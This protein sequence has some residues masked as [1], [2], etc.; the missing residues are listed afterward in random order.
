MWKDRRATIIALLGAAFVAACGGGESNPNPSP[1]TL[2]KA[3]ADDGDQ[4]TGP[5]SN[6]LPN[7]L[8]VIVTR[9]GTPEFGVTVAWATN[10]GSLNPTS[11]T[12]DPSG[13]ATSTWVLGEDAGAQAAVA[14]VQGATGSPVTFTA[15]ATSAL[16]PP[17]PPNQ[18]EVTVGN[19]FFESDRNGTSNQAVDT[20]AVNGTVTWTWVNTGAVSHSVQSTGSPSFTSSNVQ[21]GDNSTYQFQFTTAG[22]YSYNCAVHGNQMTGRIVVR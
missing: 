8:R 17:P 5:V 2:A 10:D 9:D 22:T 11:G 19:N 15:T 12:T 7:P 6:S 14:A 18:V 3:P 21:T 1:L 4:Q 20:V 16:P 13:I